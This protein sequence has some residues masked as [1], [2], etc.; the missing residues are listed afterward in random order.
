MEP[1]DFRNGIFQLHTSVPDFYPALR[2]IDFCSRMLALLASSFAYCA[3][4]LFAS[5][6]MLCTRQYSV[7]CLFTFDWLRSLKRLICP[8]LKCGRSGKSRANFCL[9]SD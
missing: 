3:N 7:H 9:A 5:F 8:P 4:P 6:S 2:L 1:G